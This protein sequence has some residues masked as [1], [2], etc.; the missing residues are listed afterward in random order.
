MRKFLSLFILTGA[1]L[2]PT[3][4]LA[5]SDTG[6]LIV[7]AEAYQQ[8]SPELKAQVF[9]I[10]KSHPEFEKWEKAYHPN[11]TLDLPATV[12]MR[13][14]TWPDEIRGGGSIYDH[15]M[16]H[17]IDY[18]LRPPN[19]AFE[20]DE[21]PTNNILFGIAQCET[22]LSDT[23]ANAELRAAYLS[24][25]VHLVGDIHQPLHCESLYNDTYTNGDRGGNDI[26]LRP[27]D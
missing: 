24:Y 26:S 5:W 8:L 13:C 6:H 22:T 20:A 19:F 27:R 2:L 11:P 15:P 4:A 21:R 10:L 25:L 3:L 7:A 18:P 9:E 17:F 16:W 14:A 23:N 1:T 12:F